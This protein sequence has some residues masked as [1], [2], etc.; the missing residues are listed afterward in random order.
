VQVELEQPAKVVLVAAPLITE[1]TSGLVV[2]VVE[3]LSRE[4]PPSTV[5]QTVVLVEQV[6]HHQLLVLQLQELAVV[7]VLLDITK[8]VLVVLVAVD[9]A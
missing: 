8:L 9:E 4:L 6:S 1:E 7:A 3:L 2:V 5:A